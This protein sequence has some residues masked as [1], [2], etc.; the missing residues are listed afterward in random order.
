[1]IDTRVK[2]LLFDFDGI[3][4]D[5]EFSAFQSW[6]EIYNDH[7]QEL[8]LDAW[9]ACLGTVGGFDPMSYLQELTGTLIDDRREI[10]QRR[11]ERKTELLGEENLRPGL[12]G[13]LARAA[14]LGVKMAIVSSAE[15][16]WIASNLA[17]LGRVEGW[18]YI[19]CANGDPARAKPHP[20]LYDEAL[21]ALNI[22]ADEALAF[23]DS[24]NGIQ[25]AKAAGLFCV[26]VSNPVTKPLDL[27]AGDLHLD[28]FEDMA[29]D[30]VLR[31]AS[32]YFLT[33]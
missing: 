16:D 7:G 15:D 30:D 3:V 32:A 14:E 2:A 8:T 19:N 9:A 5:T 31:A 18:E 20:C 22:T 27:S 4:I 29:L 33:A 17:R 21:A 6:Q 1:M 12:E 11:W 23:E 24:P 26:V 10:I 13:Y 28:S 25:A